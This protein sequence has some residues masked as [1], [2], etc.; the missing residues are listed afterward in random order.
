MNENLVI[1]SL[2]EVNMDSKQMTNLDPFDFIAKVGNFSEKLRLNQVCPIQKLIL[3]IMTVRRVFNI[4]LLI[5][6]Y[7]ENLLKKIFYQMGLLN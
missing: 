5:E 1:N 3:I 2:N 6:F 7:K 4:L